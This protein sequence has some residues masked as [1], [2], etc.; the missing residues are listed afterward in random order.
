VGPLLNGAGAPLTKDMEKA[1][2]R[3]A[4]FTLVF[5]GKIGFQESHALK[6][7]RKV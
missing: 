3:N 5:T 6:T 1:K 4:F 7:H 2:V